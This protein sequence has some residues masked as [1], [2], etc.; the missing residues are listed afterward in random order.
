MTDP[1]GSVSTR[2]AAPDPA[3]TKNCPVFWPPAFP[4]QV[5]LIEGTLAMGT[6][7]LFIVTAKRTFPIRT[8]GAACAQAAPYPAVL[9][10][11]VE[12]GRIH[13][14]SWF[15]ARRGLRRRETCSPAWAL[16]ARQAAESSPVVSGGQR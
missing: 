16:L 8:R 4:L 7:L 15:R 6:A 10:R 14:A 13:L 2:R 1:A 5:S 11:M 9:L 3:D 12:F